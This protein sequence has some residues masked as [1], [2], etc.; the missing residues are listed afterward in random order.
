MKTCP[1]C[2]C[3]LRRAHSHAV[4][5]LGLK[6]ASWVVCVWVVGAALTLPVLLLVLTSRVAVSP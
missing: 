5:E 1:E 4:A 3:D 6:A 2:G